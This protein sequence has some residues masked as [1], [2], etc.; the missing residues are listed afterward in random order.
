MKTFIS[1]IFLAFLVN[2]ASGQKLSRSTISATGNANE[3]LSY[4]VGDLIIDT[5]INGS[6]IITQGFQQP[7]ETIEPNAIDDNAANIGFEIYPNPVRDQAYLRIISE[8]DISLY[9]SIMDLQGKILLKSDRIRPSVK[10]VTKFD[11][12]HLEAGY[13]F[14]ILHDKDGKS[15]KNIK[16]LKM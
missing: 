14:M 16:F 1:A 12:K 8:D 10:D 15:Y 9:A 3:L 11:T 4:T 6:F 7:V 13:Y 5:K 2:L